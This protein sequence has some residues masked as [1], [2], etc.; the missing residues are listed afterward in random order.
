MPVAAA[1]PALAQWIR[2]GTVLPDLRAET[3]EGV[4]DEIATGLARS[5]PA[6]SA[7]LLAAGFRER[8]ALG[9]TALGGG[10]ALP[11]CR[12]PGTG[13]VRMAV[14]RHSVGVPFGASDGL[15]V[16]LFFA[17]AAPQSGPSAHLEALRAI[18]HFLKAPERRAELLAAASAADLRALFEG[19]R[20]SRPALG[21]PADG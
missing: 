9:S 3:P 15:P 1:P 6:L 18:A 17:L 14:A 10:F 12:V 5:F 13:P 11:H 16:R 20:E 7:P 4:L 2:S 21:E 8:E 19:A